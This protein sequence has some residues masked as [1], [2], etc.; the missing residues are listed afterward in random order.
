LKS[1]QLSKILLEGSTDQ[2]MD[3]RVEHTGAMMPKLL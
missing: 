2:S 3:S 1:I